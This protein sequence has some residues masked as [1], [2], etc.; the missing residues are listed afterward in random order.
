MST[1]LDPL[2]PQ[3]HIAV[4]PPAIRGSPSVLVPRLFKTGSPPPAPISPPPNG[5]VPAEPPGPSTFSA[6]QWCF[7]S[8]II[9]TLR[10]MKTAGPFLNPV[11]PLELGIP[12]YPQVIERPMDFSTIERKLAA[13]NPSKPDPNP[14]YARYYRV[15]QFVQDVRLVFANSVKFNG[16]EHPVTRMGKQVE[17]VFDKQIKQMPPPEEPEAPTP[18]AGP[19]LFPPPSSSTS[20]PPSSPPPKKRARRPPVPVPVAGGARNC[21]MSNLRL[22]PVLSNHPPHFVSLAI[23]PA[24]VTIPNLLD[25]W[26]AVPAKLRWIEDQAMGYQLPMQSSG[27]GYLPFPHDAK[28]VSAWY[29]TKGRH[30]ASVPVVDDSDLREKL[31]DMMKAKP[32]VARLYVVAPPRKAVPTKTPIE[33]RRSKYC[34]ILHGGATKTSPTVPTTP[35]APTTKCNIR[36]SCA[37]V[38]R[39]ALSA[40]QSEAPIYDGRLPKVDHCGPHVSLYHPGLAFMR[41]ALMTDKHLSRVK[42]D[43]DMELIVRKLLHELSNTVIK[44]EEDYM[45]VMEGFFKKLFPSSKMTFHR[46]YTIHRRGKKD[47]ELDFVVTCRTPYG[48]DAILV[49]GEAKFRDGNGGSAP[50]QALFGY[51]RIHLESFIS[52][53]FDSSSCPCIMV[54]ASGFLLQ[55][56]AAI[57]TEAV[58]SNQ[59]GLRSLMLS[60]LGVDDTEVMSLARVFQVLRTTAEM[61][62]KSYAENHT[63]TYNEPDALFPIPCSVPAAGVAWAP[64]QF[65]NFSLKFK[66]ICFTTH[67]RAL[68]KGEITIPPP[69]TLASTSPP[70]A[71]LTPTVVKVYVKFMNAYGYKV[72]RVLANE[73]LAP[74]LRWAGPVVG[75][76]VMVIMDA[77]EG[78]TVQEFLS[79]KDHV[80][81]TD[82]K[83][84]DDALAILRNHGFVHGDLRAPNV[85][86]CPGEPLKPNKAY[87]IDFDLAGVLGEARYPIHRLNDDVNWPRSVEEM[88]YELIQ[89]GDDAYMREHM[90]D[91]Q[92]EPP[93]T[94]PK[95]IQSMGPSTSPHQHGSNSKEST[96]SKRKRAQQ[97]LNIKQEALEVPPNSSAPSSKRSKG[98]D[99]G[100]V[101]STQS[102]RNRRRTLR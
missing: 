3:S 11:D 100:H 28:A 89:E 70:F 86:L 14:T 66:D 58:Y 51:R 63:G 16:P 12:H 35:T 80:S 17:R 39:H 41:H 93:E 101:R 67:G 69:T 75:G 92:N 7:S 24:E 40:A 26:G 29:S 52:S 49:A 38:D 45:D 18:V 74:T 87:I 1:P 78:R 72:H 9:R 42:L 76:N 23:N 27:S 13:S 56:D 43:E 84:L 2:S 95:E 21:R 46:K 33:N 98:S 62:A 97:D 50:T 64:R 102:T 19:P 5:N 57:F 61:L 44:N 54:S 65:P 90:L 79:K 25:N 83:G 48:E 82:L 36:P 31:Q 6:A 99:S 71:P 91:E 30:L 96:L 15:D 81:E 85:V 20:S 22:V 94:S 68:F 10:R 55:I 32:C 4:T 34:T 60:G 73:G 77:V 59:M 37:A 47:T 53:V 8:S 88:I